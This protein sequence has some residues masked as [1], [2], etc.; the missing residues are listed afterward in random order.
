MGNASPLFEIPEI[1]PLLDLF[2]AT[3][4]EDSH[5]EILQRFTLFLKLAKAAP[6]VRESANAHLVITLF[7]YNVIQ[8]RS[9]QNAPFAQ[10]FRRNKSSSKDNYLVKA[11]HNIP[12]LKQ[13]VLIR[14]LFKA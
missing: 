1:S 8:G 9:R 10:L 14:F 6:S 13:F 5:S 7:N 4:N 12:A 2:L 3:G 11:F